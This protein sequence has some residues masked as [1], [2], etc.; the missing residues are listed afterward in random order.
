MFSFL[1]FL[2]VL[3]VLLCF[4]SYAGYPVMIWI[5]GRL[6]PLKV[7]KKD[8]EPFVSIILAAY[9]EEKDI[10]RKIRNTLEADYPGD[11][12]EILVGSDGSTDDTVRIV[13]THASERVRLFDFKENRGKTAVQNDL[14]E[15][16]KGDVLVFT[17]AASFTPPDALRKIVRNFSD[18]RV[19]CVAGRM[20][21]MGTDVNLTTQSQGLYWRYEVTIRHMESTLGSLIGA[22]GPLYAVRRDCYVPLAPNMISD[23]LTPL[24]VLEKKKKAVL[25]P[26]ALVEEDPTEKPEQEFNTRRRITL[27]GLVGVFGHGRLLNPFKHPLLATQ[28]FLH[29]VLRWFVG[30]LVLVNTLACIALSGHG[31]FRALL[32][33][34]AAFF[35]AAAAGWLTDR[36]GVKLRLFTVPYYFTLVNMAATMGIVDYFRRRQTVTWKPVR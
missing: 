21:Y 34:Y 9:N 33:A 18:E 19:G 6:F 35:L 17:D 4:M 3:T 16:A 20:H 22:D 30:P 28:I 32:A 26:E 8:G 12:L 5:A 23:L 29:K 31:L 1:I 24:L 27:R 36:W 10:E 11:K 7:V 14:V 2:Y 25:E 13:E 15:E